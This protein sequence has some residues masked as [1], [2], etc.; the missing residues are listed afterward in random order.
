MVN[1]FEE[2]LLFSPLIADYAFEI[3]SSVTVVTS[4]LIPRHFSSNEARNLRPPLPF[5]TVIL[6]FEVAMDSHMD[7]FS[8]RIKKKKDQEEAGK[9]ENAKE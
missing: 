6:K 9:G 8:L 2:I 7:M 4:I 5:E 1:L 3:L